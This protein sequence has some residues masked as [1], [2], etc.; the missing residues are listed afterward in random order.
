MSDILSFIDGAL[1][2]VDY[3][4]RPAGFGI[5]RS[6]YMQAKGKS[7]DQA[8]RHLQRLVDMKILE[9]HEMKLDPNNGQLRALVFAR[10]DDWEKLKP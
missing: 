4:L 9:A 5:T 2:E 3:P 7:R 10:P 6:E 1:G 8:K